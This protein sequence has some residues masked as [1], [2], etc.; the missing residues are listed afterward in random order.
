[1]RRKLII[2]IFILVSSLSY[3]QIKPWDYSVRVHGGTNNFYVNLLGEAVMAAA[4]PYIAGAA[5]DDDF[6]WTKY[7]PVYDWHV[8]IPYN[9]IPPDDKIEQRN[10]YF[11]AP[12]KGGVGDWTIG[13]DF[14]A[15]HLLSHLGYYVDL[16][17][18]NQGFVYNDQKYTAHI[19]YPS[20]GIIIKLLDFNYAVQPIIE[21]GGGYD[22]IVGYSAKNGTHE[23][24]FR[25]GIVANL[26]L[27]VA[28]TRW[29]TMFSLQYSQN[30]YNSMKQEFETADSTMPFA[31]SKR[32]NAD[33]AL[34]V[35]YF[36]KLFK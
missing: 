24:M 12:W 8:G 36:W 27:G 9:T 7:M 13:I 1:M 28:V 23:N 18:K 16:D 4:I 31:Y 10:G 22:I 33:I 29:H 5:S 15:N 35:T 2:F 21:L 34:R 30:C 6:L 19:L 17:Y 11:A 20:A 26:A 3:S 25:G 14:R 32:L